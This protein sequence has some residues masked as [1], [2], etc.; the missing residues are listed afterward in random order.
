MAQ[1][2]TCV[3]S[4]GPLQELSS[5]DGSP[6]WPLISNGCLTDW[7]VKILPRG[8]DG[9]VRFSYESFTFLNAENS[10]VNIQCRLI[11]CEENLDCPPVKP[12]DE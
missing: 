7:T 10:P 8:D 4:P 1:L 3:T 2:V 11:I 9:Q 12:C 5:T 6:I